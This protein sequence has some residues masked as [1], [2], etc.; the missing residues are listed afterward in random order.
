MSIE[1]LAQL[2]WKYSHAI[3]FGA[4][5]IWDNNL[6][7][8]AGAYHASPLSLSDPMRRVGTGFLPT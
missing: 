4:A 3:S 7:M 6:F 1:D 8:A 5:D 2:V